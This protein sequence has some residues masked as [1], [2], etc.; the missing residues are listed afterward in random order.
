MLYISR[1][2][3]LYKAQLDGIRCYISNIKCSG[4]IRF[5]IDDTDKQVYRRMVIQ[6]VG[7]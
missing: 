5:V 3:L 1:M 6:S 2:I 7:Y 4:I